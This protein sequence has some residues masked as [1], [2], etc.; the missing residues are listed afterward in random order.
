MQ[1]AQISAI[2]DGFKQDTIRRKL[3]SDVSFA[4][5]Q[6]ALLQ[7]LA[8]KKSS[9][10]LLE[11][12]INQKCIDNKDL[13]AESE[14]LESKASYLRQ[15]SVQ[16]MHQLSQIHS[17]LSSLTSSVS[18]AQASKKIQKEKE[19]MDEKSMETKLEMLESLMCMKIMALSGATRFIFTHVD[20]KEVEDE[21]MFVVGLSDG[22]YA[23]I[24]TCEA[25]YTRQRLG[26][27]IFTMPTSIVSALWNHSTSLGWR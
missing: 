18:D 21:F 25:S 2:F 19:L 10:T 27:D 17:D 1:I 15:E 13:E 6:T 11:Y 16:M 14:R 22:V 26:A 24:L 5:A 3:D 20:P 4:A 8:D 9:L 7:T 12:K 23:G